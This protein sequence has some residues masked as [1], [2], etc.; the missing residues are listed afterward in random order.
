[1]SNVVL[2]R[3]LDDSYAT[4]VRRDLTAFATARMTTNAC[5]RYV[6]PFIATIARGLHVTLADIGLAIAISELSGLASPLIGRIVDRLGAR[7]AVA[8]GM[9]AV[10]AGTC[11]AAASQGV[12][13]LAAALVILGLGNSTFY[14]GIG[15]WIAMHVPY[16]RRGRVTGLIEV[17][18]AFGLLIGVSTMGL[19]TAATN[20]RIGYLSGAAAVAM[21]GVV[22]I[23]R[24]DPPVP[25]P[26]R[27]DGSTP[28]HGRLV[29][30]GWLVLLA[31]FA[32]TAASHSLFVT[33]GSWLEDEFGFTP[34]GISAVSFV[35]GV[36]ELI[37]TLSVA[38]FTDVWGKRRSMATGT[39]LMIPASIGL[40]LWHHTLILGVVLLAIAV[41]G[42]EFAV[43]SGISLGTGLV[44]GSPARGLGLLIGVDTVGRAVMSVPATRLYTQHGIGWPAAL[45]AMLATI[46]VVTIVLSGRGSRT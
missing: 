5:Y 46:G 3:V 12:P 28:P 36:G 41:L 8:I 10:F 18:W 33:F 37:A 40:A 4:E 6:A 32:M 19:V 38:R 42:F 9:V 1:M 17:S 44:P 2:G 11:V 21:L 29:P 20:W 35:L 22:V 43:V 16:E 34:A 15:S 25:V 39:A 23:G 27:P 26:R 7:R 30:R 45:A 14:L 13:M 31:G 24:I